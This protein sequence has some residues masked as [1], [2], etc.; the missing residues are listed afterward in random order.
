MIYNT[1]VTRRKLTR[2][3]IKPVVRYTKEGYAPKGY[4][5]FTLDTYKGT[6]SFQGGYAADFTDCYDSRGNKFDDYAI[7]TVT[8]DVIDLESKE[9]KFNISEIK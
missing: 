1:T 5:H 8:G 9:I 6:P 4:Y 7:D 2:G 3:T